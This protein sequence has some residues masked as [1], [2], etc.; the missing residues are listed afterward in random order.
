MT[1][2]AQIA[3]ITV[4]TT[5][6]PVNLLAWPGLPKAADL[7]K[8]G[9]RSLS[10]LSGVSQIVWQRIRK[11]PEAFL[12]AG[13]SELFTKGFMA[14]GELQNCSPTRSELDIQ[15]KKELAVNLAQLAEAG[16][17]TKVFDPG[18]TISP[19]HLIF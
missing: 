11:L 19:E 10:A 16:H 15:A 14:H 2:L 7:A 17:F 8:L 5:K 1:E 6:L 18:H 13:D 3:Q 9:V 12:A 4:E